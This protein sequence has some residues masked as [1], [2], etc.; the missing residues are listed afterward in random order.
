M[1]LLE[2]SE[3]CYKGVLR[4]AAL[5]WP[6]SVRSVCPVYHQLQLLPHTA[7]ANSARMGPG[8]ELNSGT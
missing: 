5:L 4:E 6:L 7:L 3:T 1:H 8:M 2:P